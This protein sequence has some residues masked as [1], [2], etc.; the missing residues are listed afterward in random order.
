M[1]LFCLPAIKFE[2][3]LFVEAPTNLV[4]QVGKELVR[5]SITGLFNG[6]SIKVYFKLFLLRGIPT[7]I[8]PASHS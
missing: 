2:K 6:T 8:N 7:L 1:L 3:K 4:C 5:R